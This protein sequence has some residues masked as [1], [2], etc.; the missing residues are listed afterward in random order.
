MAFVYY[1]RNSINLYLKIKKKD[2]GLPT[3]NLEI[4]NPNSGRTKIIK[5]RYIA[6]RSI[7][8]VEMSTWDN[9]MR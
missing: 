5:V 2:M 7:Q 6:P 8:C 3:T 1:A 4:P 9:I